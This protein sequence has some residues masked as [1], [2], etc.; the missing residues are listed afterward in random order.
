VLLCPSAEGRPNKYATDY[1]TLT[2]IAE[3]NY[4]SSIEAGGALTKQKRSTEKL[5]GPLTDVTN[6]IRKVSDGMSKTFMFFESAGRPNHYVKNAVDSVLPEMASVSR[7]SSTPAA[8]SVTIPH[9]ATQWADDQTF[10]GV[11]G[12]NPTAACPIA[13]IMSCDNSTKTSPTT[14]TTRSDVNSSIYSFHS[15]G[16]QFLLGDGS[17]S[18]LNENMDMDTFL[19]MFTAAADDTASPVN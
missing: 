16:A 5:L 12:Q 10:D 4:C 14:D 13:T 8:P 18:F 3:A 7:S 9:E 19:S 2:K 15:G 1:I 11:W 6:T 17:V